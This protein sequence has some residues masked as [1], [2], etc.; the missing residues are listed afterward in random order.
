MNKVPLFLLK[1]VFLLSCIF[2][3]AEVS[4]HPRVERIQQVGI[5]NQGNPIKIAFAEQG[6]NDGRPTIVFLDTYFG[7]NA[8]KAHQEVLSEEFY[9]IAVDPIG[10][11]A[12][13]KNEPVDL[14]GFNGFE[15][16]SFRQQANLYHKFFK[17]IDVQ[18]PITFVALDTHFQ[19][20]MWYA[21]DYKDKA[22]PIARLVNIQGTPDAIVSNDP[23]SYAFVTEEQ[24]AALISF[25]AFDPCACTRAII[26]TSF[27][28]PQCPEI[29][30]YLTEECANFTATLPPSIFERLFTR[31]FK[32]S[33]IPLM[34]QIEI[35]FLSFYG[36]T[37]DAHPLSR[38][39]AAAGFTQLC[40]S[41]P[42]NNVTLPGTCPCEGQSSIKPFPNVRLV[43]YP[44]H[45][46]SLFYTAFKRFVKDI[47]KF[48][49]GL[50]E[51][52]HISPTP[53]AN[54]VIC[55]PPA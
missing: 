32:E 17:R 52:C 37:G 36:L 30:P 44:G 41:C 28:T 35:P 23:C 48:A 16:Y 8:Y 3:N 15:G 10:Y 14:D 53:I 9:T 49:L 45:G 34:E 6:I 46:T 12:S 4:A 19:V 25:F 55:P 24:A 39:A 26:S 50:D 47:R 31:T 7:K 42:D 13:T 21:V 22:K 40:K 29:V 27:F 54:P 5:D 51:A 33:V 38:Q 20:G 11:G 1:A 43:V 2:S 18:G